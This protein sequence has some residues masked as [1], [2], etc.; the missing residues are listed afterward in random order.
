M[1]AVNYGW[2]TRR[3]DFDFLM[4]LNDGFLGFLTRC[5]SLF[6]KNISSFV[7]MFITLNYAFE[8]VNGEKGKL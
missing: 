1:G 5:F 8:I 2:G 4:I 7:S 3:Y 6:I